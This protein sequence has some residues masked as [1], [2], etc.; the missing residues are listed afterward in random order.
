MVKAAA[1]FV[2]EFGVRQAVALG[3]V[4]VLLEGKFSSCFKQWIKSEDQLWCRE[5]VI[6][7]VRTLQ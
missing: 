3:C 2:P 1:V 4:A 6:N 5:Q 7:H